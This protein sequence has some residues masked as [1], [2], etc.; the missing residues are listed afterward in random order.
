MREPGCVGGVWWT[1]LCLSIL[2]WFSFGL[3]FFTWV[4]EN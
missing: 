3:F 1:V 4:T 2:I